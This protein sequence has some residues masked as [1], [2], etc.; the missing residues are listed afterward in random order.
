MYL[1][2][3][4]YHVSE[5][6]H[7]NRGFRWCLMKM[8]SERFVETVLK[9]LVYYP[10]IYRQIL[11]YTLYSCD[12]NVQ[13]DF[14]IDAISYNKDNSIFSQP[15]SLR[16]GNRKRHRKKKAALT[17]NLDCISFFA[18]VHSFTRLFVPLSTSSKNTGRAREKR[19]I[20]GQ[21]V[22]GRK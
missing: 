4:V 6:Q 9:S 7:E 15:I 20:L 19:N 8:G 3:V 22:K 13:C 12:R 16:N 14:L 1:A 10:T 18:R 5:K 17:G 21:A 2:V 11:H